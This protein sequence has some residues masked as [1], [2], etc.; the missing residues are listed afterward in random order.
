AC[1]FGESCRYVHDANAKLGNNSLGSN[2]VRGATVDTINEL[3]SK[4]SPQLGTL[5]TNTTSSSNSANTCVPIIPSPGPNAFLVGPDL[6]SGAWNMD[7]GASSHLNNSVNSLSENFNTSPSPIPHVFFVSQ[8][9]WHQRLGHPGGEVLPRLVS[10]NFI[11]YNKEKPLVLCHACQLGKHVRLPFVSSSTV[12][13]SCFDIIHSAVWTSPI[14]SLSG[15]KYYNAFLHGDLSETVYMH[16]PPG[17]Q[18]SVHPDYVCLLQRP[19]IS[20]A[21][22]Q[23]TLDYDLQLVSSSTTDLVAYSDADW[24]GCPTTQRSTSGYY[25]FLGNNLLSWSSKRQSTLSHSSAKTEY[26]GVANDVA[27]TF[28]HQRTKHIEIDIHF[29][30]DLVVA[31][32]VECFMCRLVISLQIFS[33]RDCRQHYLKNFASV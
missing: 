24:A 1:R 7:T 12:I 28:H 18:D 2:R 13:S 21:V 16:Q 4:L 32:Q 17:F 26:R 5:T 19:D 6:A 22:Q 3:L 20:Y 30:R 8:H 31:G 10:S 23:G 25:V 14:S 11:S 29:V 33:P 9:T 27:E 15:F